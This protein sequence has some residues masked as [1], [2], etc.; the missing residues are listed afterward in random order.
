MGF[1]ISRNENVFVFRQRRFQASAH[2]FYI[3]HDV[4][5]VVPVTHRRVAIV[6]IEFM[7]DET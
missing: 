2:R 3:K 6:A 4:N 1:P 5:T 7:E